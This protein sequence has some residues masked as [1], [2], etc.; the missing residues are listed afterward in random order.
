MSTDIIVFSN[1]Q[2]TLMLTASCGFA[3]MVLTQLIR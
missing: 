1:D 3:F 2:F